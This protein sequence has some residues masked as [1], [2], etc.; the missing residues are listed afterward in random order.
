M[1]SLGYQIQLAV[2]L[3]ALIA[4]AMVP[5]LREPAFKM[6]L[7]DRPGGRKRHCGSVPLSGGIAIFIAFIFAAMMMGTSLQPYASLLVGMAVMLATGLL[8]DLVEISPGVKM[9]AQVLA[10]LL[11]VSWGEVQITNLGMI[12]G[13]KP[14]ELGEWAIPFTVLCVLVLIN[15][16]NMVD[17]SDGLAGSLVAVIL[18]MLFTLSVVGGADSELSGLIAILLAAVLAFLVYNFRFSRS[19]QAKVFLGDSGSLMLGYAVAWLAVYISQRPEGVGAP[20]MTIAWILLLPALD[21][22]VLFI[23]RVMRGRSPFSADS[24]H[25]H[26]VLLRSGFSVRSTVLL[27][28]VVTSLFGWFGIHAWQNDWPEYWLFAATVPVFFIHYLASMRAWRVVRVMRKV[29]AR[30]KRNG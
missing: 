19:R 24:E 26:H 11:M 12:V 8:D 28:I 16:I 18:V 21:V 30:L 6:N 13:L 23:R 22:L 2:V 20:P 17:G 10:A 1:F 15:A 4:L 29:R 7:V 9:A 3:S 25:L 5:I 14:V 27:L